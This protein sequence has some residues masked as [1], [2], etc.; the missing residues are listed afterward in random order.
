MQ[1]TVSV[2]C[3]VTLDIGEHG[4][5]VVGEKTYTD[6]DTIYADPG[7]VLVFTFVPDSGYEVEKAFY[8][9]EDITA[10]AKSGIYKTDAADGDITLTVCFKKKTSPPSGGE[11]SSAKTGD[12]VRYRLCVI[13]MLISGAALTGITLKERKREA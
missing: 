3:K 12:T 9:S 8:G 6:G 4:S 5:V 10:A 13:L 11:P 1:I 7:A 2:P